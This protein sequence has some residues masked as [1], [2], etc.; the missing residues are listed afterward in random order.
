MS[1]RKGEIYNKA[2]KEKKKKMKN[3]MKNEKNNLFCFHKNVWL[4]SF[5]Q[6]KP[7]RTFP[8]FNPYSPP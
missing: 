5:Q 3:E 7:Q 6:E 2:G 4:P 1:Q 8:F